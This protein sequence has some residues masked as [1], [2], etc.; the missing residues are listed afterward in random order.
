M[1]SKTKNLL[2]FFLS[3]FLILHFL[4]WQKFYANCFFYDKIVH[5][6]AGASVIL[7]VIWLIEKH[8][9]HIKTKNITLIALFILLC[10]ALIWEIFEYSVDQRIGRVILEPLQSDRLDT[11]GDFSANFLGGG[12]IL[13]FQRKNKKQLLK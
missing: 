6:F 3:F 9:F 10:I 4:G 11:L 5:F 12:I 7:A 2:I 13:L 1:F 8:I